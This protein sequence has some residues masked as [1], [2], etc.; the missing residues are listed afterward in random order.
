V[1][2][3]L[4]AVE[5]VVK[6]TRT[7]SGKYSLTQLLSHSRYCKTSDPRDRIYS[8]LGL[9]N[10][11][12]GIVPDYFNENTTVEVFKVTK[13]FILFEDSLDFL[14]L[15][16]GTRRTL[17]DGLPLWVPDG[18]SR[19][20]PELSNF[21]NLTGRIS[22]RVAEAQKPTHPSRILENKMTRVSRN[23][24][25]F[26]SISWSLNWILVEDPLR[27]TG[28]RLN[29]AHSNLQRGIWLQQHI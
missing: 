10:Q 18:T 7:W 12:Y 25:V 13:K 15:A 21:R 26:S 27:P 4:E 29:A 5:F 20:T 11:N 28:P 9:A 22:L 17:T 19:E 16:P 2:A 1:A 3:A 24:W 23:H 14:T 6:S 8:F